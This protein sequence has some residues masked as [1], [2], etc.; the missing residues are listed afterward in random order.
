MFLLDDITVAVLAIRY[1]NK[2]CNES[3]EITITYAVSVGYRSLKLYV[4]FLLRRLS[5]YNFKNVFHSS[6]YKRKRLLPK[7]NV[8]P[9]PLLFT[10]RYLPRT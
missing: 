4:R 1:D 5:V 10:L 9:A 6:R 2:K 3:K 7:G 8:N